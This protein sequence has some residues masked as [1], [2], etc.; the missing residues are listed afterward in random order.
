VERP[1]GA[2]FDA[3]IQTLLA[4]APIVVVAIDL[5]GTLTL[6]EGA[7]LAPLGLSTADH[8]GRSV[9]ELYHDVPWLLGA[10]RCGLAGSASSVIGE[11]RGTWYYVHYVPLRDAGGRVTGLS[12]LALDVTGQMHVSGLLDGMDAI[13]WLV[14]AP[15]LRFTFVSGR[16]QT[17]LGW[18]PSQWLAEEDFWARLLAPEER[19]RSLARCRA[20]ADDGQSR[21]WVHRLRAADGR[22]LWCV[23]T[24]RV[25]GTSRAGTRTL[26]GMT[27]DITER[28]RIDELI[29]E[30][31]ARQRLLLEQMPAVLWTV[32]RDLRFTS[33]AG[34]GLRQLGLDPDILI[35]STLYEYFQTDSPDD[36]IIAPIRRVVEHGDSVRFDALWIGRSFDVHVEPF[37][38]AG[39]A[40]IGAL[41]IALDVTER[42]RAER[43]RDRLLERE[44]AA[45]AVAEAAVLARDEFLSVASH[46]LRTPLTALRLAVQSCAQARD[47]RTAAEGQTA[48]MLGLAMK[49]VQRLE[50]LVDDLLDVSRI[51]GGQLALVLARF[52]V[53]ELVREVLER[54]RPALDAARCPVDLT[55]P[56]PQ[57]LVCRG[58]RSRLDQVVTNLLSNAMKFAAGKP[59]ALRLRREGEQCVLEVEDRGAGI[60]PERLPYVFDRFERAVTTR[61]FGGLGIG[62]YLVDRIVRAHGGAVEA[63]SEP[64]AG[65][66]FTV[67]L[68]LAGPNPE[69]A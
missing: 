58:D 46:E 60:P 51:Q 7:G 29:R 14:E 5:D 41:G 65:A 63:R 56:D 38:D 30:T 23:T 27:L 31:D 17:L 16:A 57:T 21:Q 39:G 53:V 20:V 68:P 61:Q 59:I 69:A 34:A 42:R 35:G 43:E 13:V 24:V 32:D 52:D 66:A 37:R 54:T 4:E 28:M 36:P 12:G 67:R 49:Q 8:V 10:V 62:L 22:V 11:V 45:R 48:R 50:R 40:I 15:A 47:G 44:Q 1:V 18:P 55:A 3:A 6:V 26:L 64:G 19:E 33:S 25:F 9:F 2:D